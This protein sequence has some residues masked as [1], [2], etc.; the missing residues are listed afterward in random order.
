MIL[1]QSYFYSKLLES[2]HDARHTFIIANT[3]KNK[4]SYRA[5]HIL[6]YFKIHEDS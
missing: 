3:Y 4:L 1:Q 5:S 6:K 2:S